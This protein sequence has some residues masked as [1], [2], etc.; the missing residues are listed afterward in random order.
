[1]SERPYTLVAELTYRCPLRCLYCSNPVELAA[2][3]REPKG[4]ELDTEGWRRVL[5]EAEALGVVQVNFSGGE[6]LLRDDLQE[7]VA[8]ARACE[9][10]SNLITSGVP[11]ERARLAALAERG[12]DAVQVSFQDDRPGAARRI[13]GVDELE[14]KLRVAGWVRELGLPLTVNAVLQRANLDR[15]AEIV[16]LA[17]KLGAERLELANT[18]YL[19]W[20]LV[21]RAALLPTRAQIERAR[22]EA[23]AAADRLKGRMEILFVLPDYHTDLPRACMGGWASRH[24]VV[25]PD[26][27]ALPCHQA[28]GI[29]GLAFASVRERPLDA[30]WNDSP[31]F[32]AFRGEAWMQEPCRSCPRRAIDFGGCRCQA[33]QLTGDAGATDPACHLSPRH[34]LVA[35]AVRHAEASP[36]PE[37]VYRR[38]PRPR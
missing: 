9:L 19:G 32:A 15:V 2:R 11:L 20:A 30:L 27:V 16:A 3:L 24:L 6:P 21:N 18:T 12:L 13:A 35:E 8:E 17:E 29:A 5:R 33:F 22:A 25:A 4:G 31:G 28:R 26:G 14:Q 37:L 23:Q 38:A 36:E 7:L 1:M 34:A 10:Y